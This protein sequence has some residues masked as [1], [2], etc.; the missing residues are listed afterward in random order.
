MYKLTFTLTFYYNNSKVIEV[1][2]FTYTEM[3]PENRPVPFFF[4]FGTHPLK[5]PTSRYCFHYLIF[6]TGRFP[7]EILTTGILGSEASCIVL[8]HGPLRCHFLA[9]SQ[10]RPAAPRLFPRV[11]TQLFAFRRIDSATIPRRPRETDC[12][13]LANT[14]TFRG[15]QNRCCDWEFCVKSKEN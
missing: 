9:A 7:E 5:T 13:L 4:F 1:H 10:C 14:S 6:I 3:D 12:R 8:H 11:S 2:L 15:A